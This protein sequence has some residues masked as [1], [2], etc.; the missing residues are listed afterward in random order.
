[1]FGKIL[2]IGES[3]AHIQNAGGEAAASDLMNLHVVF[4]YQTERILGEIFE[5]DK[6]IIKISMLGEFIDS[7]YVNGVLRKPNLNSQLRIIN[8][9]ELKILVGD[10]DGKSI[11]LGDHASYKGFKVAPKLN[12]LFASHFAIF[13]NSGSGKSYG[14]SRI[15]QNIF[16]NPNLNSVGANIFIFDSFGEY[17][18][19]FCKLNELNQSYNYK[20]IT[21]NVT[22]NTDVPLTIPVNLLTTDD[23]ALLLQADSHSQLTII[24]N[25]IKLAKVF[26]MNDSQSTQYKNHLIAKALIAIMFS[27]ETNEAKKNEIFKIIE[28]CNTEQFD[29][30]A[31][32]KGLGY[33][34][35]FSECFLIDSN[36]NFGESVLI[37][38]YVLK[39]VDENIESFE[40]PK[41]TSFS[42][43]D[44]RNALE[45]TLIS[46]GFLHN[47]T[48]YDTAII[49]RV[50]LNAIINSK[51]NNVF[52]KA[53]QTPE[54]YINSLIQ[55]NGGKAQII[56]I[57]MEE[58][59]DNYAKVIVKII[60]KIMF[61]F[62]KS[63]DRRAEM[64]F[65]LICEEAHRYIQADNDN[66]LLGYNIFERIAKEGRKYGV[67]LGIISQ[68]PV[69]ISDT[70][71][72][73]LSNFLIFKMTHPLD[74][75]YIEDMLPNISA[76]VV[77]K[78]K[79]LQPGT[80]V[81]F[82]AAFK[83]PMIVKLEIP[84]P[85]PF[86]SSCNVERVWSQSVITNTINN[87][88]SLEEL[89]APNQPVNQMIVEQA[90]TPQIPIDQMN[91]NTYS[92]VAQGEIKIDEPVL[93]SPPVVS[94][95]QNQ[96]LI[97]FNELNTGN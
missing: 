66:F 87:Q 18:T 50:R 20:F 60:S 68:R 5:L 80:C 85:A 35:T 73:Q 41:D 71:I 51:L 40:A 44:F 36:G 84:N 24:Q 13:G 89:N 95:N 83:I 69:E 27:S 11:I 72:S 7:N 64:P 59:D 52:I 79:T 70:V 26:T 77:E 47:Q 17:K 16:N 32:V 21:T 23:F 25:S 61:D 34:R 62:A 92:Q 4:E 30:N 33:S 90:V 54:T 74:V 29:F 43:Y 9:T 46:G 10:D 14:T 31:V 58:I 39:H 86:S 48:L 97:N 94:S 82:G 19:A 57:N 53:E 6:D 38:D 28:V 1:M 37:T 96:S 75:K 55:Y 65:H 93:V 63:T 49:L 42:L 12:S 22:D 2:Y 67:I 88:V 8:G 3:V 56:N 78:Q 15:F 91:N 81:G 45:F 76:D